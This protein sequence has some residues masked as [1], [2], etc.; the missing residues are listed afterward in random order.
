MPLPNLPSITLW[1]TDAMRAVAGAAG[2]RPF[3]VKVRIRTWSGARPGVG[4]RSDTDITL[5]NQ[6]VD[7]SAQNVR[8]R[9][10][11]SKDIIAS[12]G[13]Y[14]DRD[15]RVGPM[16]PSYAATFTMAAGGFGDASID[17]AP[18]NTATEIF[19]NVQGPGMPAGGE[20]HSKVGEEATELHY[21]LILRASGR[22]P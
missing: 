16:S 22:Q 1:A 9:Q 14:R 8:V 10:L 13:R 11:S 2:L 17:T 19:W 6:F 20:W 21:Y 12:G 18:T 7:G 15:L 3:T 5:T 4:A